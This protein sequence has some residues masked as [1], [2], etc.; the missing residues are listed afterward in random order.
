MQ[1]KDIFIEHQE[2]PSKCTIFFEK[3]IGANGPFFYCHKCKNTISETMKGTPAEPCGTCEICGGLM[4]WRVSKAGNK[5][6]ACWTPHKHF[7]K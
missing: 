1:R 5:Y 2:C 6:K 7:K 3:R 4:F